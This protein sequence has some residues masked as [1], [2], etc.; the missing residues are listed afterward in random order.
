MRW[1]AERLAPGWERRVDPSWIEGWQPRPFE[2]E[3]GWAEVVVLGS[4]PALILLPPLPGWKEAWIAVAGR[5]ARRFRVVTFDFRSRFGARSP[6]EA[7]LADLTRIA[8][9][10][11]PGPVAVAG[12]SLGGALAQRWALARPERVRALGLSSS[13]ARVGSAPGH[14][15]KRYVEQLVVLAGQRLLPERLAAPLARNLATRGAWVYD[16]CC[17]DRV[18]AFVRH[19]IRR[20]R[21]GLAV[22]RVRLAMT[23]DAR[24]G[25]DGIRCPTLV[26]IGERETAWAR[27]AADELARLVPGAELR[28]SP[29]V[30]HLHPLS[31]PAWFAETLGDWLEAGFRPR[32][33]GVREAHRVV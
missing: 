18:L 27:A 30:G 26:M 17:D 14:W 9:A 10:F 6:W 23:H 32:A 29:G 16:S 21:I 20:Q 22:E 5:L 13:F 31:A 7:L 1:I 11:A 33:A 25:L 8:D 4:G 28:T 3:D 2:L 19:A 12:H 24:A 15:R